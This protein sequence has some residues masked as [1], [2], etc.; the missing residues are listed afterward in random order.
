MGDK[1]FESSLELVSGRILR[2]G[3]C[4]RIEGLV[5]DTRVYGWTTYRN[6][7]YLGDRYR[8]DSKVTLS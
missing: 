2:V 6:V 8:W 1:G 4:R 3:K 5:D 7:L